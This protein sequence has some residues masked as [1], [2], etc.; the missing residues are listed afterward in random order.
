[1]TDGGVE[2]RGSEGNPMEKG[3]VRGILDRKEREPM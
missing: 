1:M 2:G 3:W